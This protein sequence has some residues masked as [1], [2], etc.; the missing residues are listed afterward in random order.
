VRLFLAALEAGGS[1]AMAA[2]FAGIARR[3]AYDR[4]ERDQA[5]ADAWERALE[6]GRSIRIRERT[7][8]TSG[9]P[10]QLAARVR[11]VRIALE[12]RGVGEFAEELRAVELALDRQARD[13]R[14]ES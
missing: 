1:I 12:R 6:A 4:R 13:L 11:A 8:R 3:T 7:E 9:A 5:F 10:D 14:R 2:R